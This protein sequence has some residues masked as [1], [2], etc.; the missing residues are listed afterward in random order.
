MIFYSAGKRKYR[1]EEAV[2]VIEEYSSVS[3]PIIWRILVVSIRIYSNDNVK[4][5]DYSVSV[6]SDG[7]YQYLILFN[8]FWPYAV[9]T[10]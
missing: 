9:M 7:I 10:L 6:R 3:N 8:L 2:M 5:S 1:S 4:Y